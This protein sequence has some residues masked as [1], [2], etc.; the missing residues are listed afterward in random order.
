MY[1]NEEIV[2]NSPS[3]FRVHLLLDGERVRYFIENYTLEDI[4]NGK[5]DNCIVCRR[6]WSLKETQSVLV[7]G[8]N[9]VSQSTNI[10]LKAC[11]RSYLIIF[12]IKKTV[13]ARNTQAVR[14]HIYK[15]KQS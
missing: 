14:K 7:C 11:C 12:K 5:M 8:S 3:L 4:V 9:M 10:F 15:D 6:E 1:R 2:V 13:N